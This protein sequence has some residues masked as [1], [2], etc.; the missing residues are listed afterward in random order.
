MKEE[1][2]EVKKTMTDIQYNRFLSIINTI[3]SYSDK[4]KDLLGKKDFVW[5]VKDK[6]DLSIVIRV[7]E[8]KPAE[9]L[10]IKSMVITQ[11]KILEYEKKLKLDFDNEINMSL[12]YDKK[13][14][15]FVYKKTNNKLRGVVKKNE[16][17]KK[18]CYM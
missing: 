13:K 6:K 3:Q 14:P 5:T 15:K 16:K 1:K 11:L 9:D 7:R 18:V 4:N 17:Y 2:K 12:S 8:Y 10:Y